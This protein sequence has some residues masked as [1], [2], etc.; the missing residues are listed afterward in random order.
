MAEYKQSEID[1]KLNE[2]VPALEKAGFTTT[3][4]VVYHA[5]SWMTVFGAVMAPVN[6]VDTAKGLLEKEY[7]TLRAAAAGRGAAVAAASA[8]AEAAGKE[9][10]Q[11][12]DQ[13]RYVGSEVAAR[14]TQLV[15]SQ[16]AADG[17]LS[18]SAGSKAMAVAVLLVGGF[19]IYKAMK[20]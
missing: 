18:A 3:D 13:A 10:E 1:R 19:F 5:P 15:E 6:A 12:E 4:G 11:A 14:V 8:A 9:R 2:V 17:I 7:A 20:R 16:K